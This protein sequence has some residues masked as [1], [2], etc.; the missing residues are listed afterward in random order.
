MVVVGGSAQLSSPLPGCLPLR[1]V[2]FLC[3]SARTCAHAHVCVCGWVRVGGC[4]RERR[5]HRRE[6]KQK[7]DTGRARKKRG[8]RGR[9]KTGF[10]A[11]EG[12][13]GLPMTCAGDCSKS[14]HLAVRLPRAPAACGSPFK[15]LEAAS[16]PFPRR[17][18]VGARAAWGQ[19]LFFCRACRVLLTI[20]SL[21]RNRKSNAE[22]VL[23]RRGLMRGEGGGDDGKTRKQT[24]EQHHKRSVVIV[25]PPPSP[26][27]SNR[28]ILVV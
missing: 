4:V 22:R 15:T 21:G 1:L 16:I 8:E 18:G 20:G 6:G 11:Q 7:E 17:R 10:H 26:A 12:V 27:C 3:G 25:S 13:E 14:I 9:G 24:N 2:V 19:A 23:G 28:S 5:L